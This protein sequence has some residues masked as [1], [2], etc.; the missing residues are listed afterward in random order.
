MSPPL[1]LENWNLRKV[2]CIK[3]LFESWKFWCFVAKARMWKACEKGFC[4]R[5]YK[6][7]NSRCFEYTRSYEILIIHWFTSADSKSIFLILWG[8]FWFLSQTS[9]G[10]NY[11]KSYEILALY[12]LFAIMS[13]LERCF[14]MQIIIVLWAHWK[15]LL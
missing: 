13:R 9:C 3:I 5:I 15:S 6:L 4:H 1:F 7:L 2:S 12:N 8:M 14:E 10:S 11:T